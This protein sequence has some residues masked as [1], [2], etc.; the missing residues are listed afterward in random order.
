MVVRDAALE[1]ARPGKGE[2]KGVC[3]LKKRQSFAQCAPHH[4]T[5]ETLDTHRSIGLRLP[6]QSAHANELKRYATFVVLV[7]DCFNILTYV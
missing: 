6:V 1:N 7:M 4:S 3:G 5:S 2:Y